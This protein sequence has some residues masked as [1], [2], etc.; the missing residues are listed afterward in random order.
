MGDG[1]DLLVFGEERLEVFLQLLQG[2]FG[3]F[4]DDFPLCLGD[5]GV[6]LDLLQV[7]NVVDFYQPLADDEEARDCFDR[8]H[9]VAGLLAVREPLRQS[10]G[11]ESAVRT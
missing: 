4:P 3:V 8:L 9:C 2:G 10:D 1:E 6:E 7:D 5:V 11:L